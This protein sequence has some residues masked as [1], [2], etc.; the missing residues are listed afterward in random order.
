MSRIDIVEVINKVSPL[1]RTG[2]NFMCCCP[3]HKEKTPSFSVS[4]QKQFFKCFGCGASGNVIG[5]LMRYEGLSYPEAIRKL[6]ESIG[7][8]VPETPRDRETR[9][10]VRSL[11]DMMKAASDYYSASL[12]TNTRTIEYLKQRGITGETAARFALGYSPDAWQP[13]KDVFGDQYASKDLEEEGGCGLV[14]HNGDKRYDRF[15]GRL[16]FPIRNPRGQVIAFGARTLNGDEHPKYL[17]SPETA[18]YHKSREIYGLYEASASIREKHRAI[19]CEGYMDVI[20]LSQAGFTEA[21]AALGTAVTAEHV[22][23]LLRAVDTVYFSFD[24]DS[25]GQHALR[26]A[27]EAALP[28]V[29]DDQEIRFVVLPPEHDPDS[30]IKEKGAQAFED[31]LQ[32]SL[33]LTQYF[34]RTVSQGKDLGTA[35]GRSQF[36]AESKPLIVSMR[37]APILRK[38]LVGELAMHARMSP[39]EIERLCGIASVRK[40]P[41]ANPA[42]GMHFDARRNRSYGGFT[43]RKPFFGTGGEPV[44]LAPTSDIRERLLQNLLN[45]PALAVEFSSRIEEEFVGS[46]AEAAREILEVWRTVTA[47]EEPLLQSQLI[48]ERLQSSRYYAHYCDLVAREMVLQ[49]PENAA[50]VEVELTF[51]RLELQRIESNLMQATLEAKPDIQRIMGLDTKRKVLKARIDEVQ[52]QFA[53][54]HGAEI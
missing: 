22:Q 23:K 52:K 37:S 36:V 5:F 32:K 2:K 41:A 7:M 53:L 46:E 15:R 1:K 26:R 27:L 42:T 16:M 47:D 40:L 29:E 39:D 33:T 10:R 50:R 19:V 45:Y 28:V 12:K 38:Q 13:L 43:P 48:L 3:F 35:E 30:L 31:E 54:H 21:C 49:T 24:G 25:A 51:D 20:Q 11:T 34:V 8:T 14:I 6:A 44:S 18:L 17:N 9:T 4:Q